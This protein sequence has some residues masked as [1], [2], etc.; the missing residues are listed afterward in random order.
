MSRAPFWKARSLFEL[1]RRNP[2][3]YSRWNSNDGVGVH[4]LASVYYERALAAGFSHPS[5]ILEKLAVP[6]GVHDSSGFSETAPTPKLFDRGEGDL[7]AISVM[8]SVPFSPDRIAYAWT[9]FRT[10]RERC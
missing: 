7:V 1:K 5:N 10:H 9:F 6:R 2:S 3:V 8:D 4:V